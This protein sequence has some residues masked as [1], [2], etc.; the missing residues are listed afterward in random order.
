MQLQ[1]AISISFQETIKSK[2]LQGVPTRTLCNW[3]TFMKKNW[4]GHIRITYRSSAKTQFANLIFA[5]SYLFVKTLYDISSTHFENSPK[6]NFA[7]TAGTSHIFKVVAQYIAQMAVCTLHRMQY[8]YTEFILC[9][10]NKL[11]DSTL[12][13]ISINDDT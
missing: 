4:Q 1:K 5:S 6:L 7:I 11:F 13:G 10:F 3:L 2:L 12:Q 8:G 9:P